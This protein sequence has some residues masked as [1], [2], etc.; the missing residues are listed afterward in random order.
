MKCQISD[1]ATLVSHEH[2]I[3]DCQ[4]RHESNLSDVR[5]SACPLD[6]MKSLQLMSTLPAL[7]EAIDAVLGNKRPTLKPQKSA[8]MIEIPNTLKR[9]R[10]IED[11]PQKKLKI[12]AGLSTRLSRIE[13]DSPKLRRQSILQNRIKKLESEWSIP[14]Q[15]AETKWMER[16]H[17]L[18][19][20]LQLIRHPPQ[21]SYDD[22]KTL[23]NAIWDCA[24]WLCEG[25]FA[26][27]GLFVQDWK[28]CHEQFSIAARF[29]TLV[30][31]MK[32]FIRSPP[33]LTHN[34]QSDSIALSSLLGSKRALYGDLLQSHGRVW[35][36]RG[37]PVDD[38]MEVIQQFQ[39]IIANLVWG[40][41]TQVKQHMHSFSQDLTHWDK[42][43]H[44]IVAPR[45][46]LGCH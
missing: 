6:D 43:T 4:E 23:V 14:Q 20:N 38:I 11:E 16:K 1:H 24:Q 41:L 31:D 39:L 7:F 27:L 33:H 17:E 5:P 35:R 42:V 34:I 21:D 15:T 40:H 13:I 36:Q 32:Q 25:D 37:F 26:H 8:T 18:E 19:K 3:K 12:N 28:T 45:R 29:V 30:E 2:P 22:V 46:T 10:H 44:L 9:Q